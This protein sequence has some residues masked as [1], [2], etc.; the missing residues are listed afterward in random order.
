MPPL[1]VISV[2]RCVVPTCGAQRGSITVHRLPKDPVR[3]NIWKQAIKNPE[4]DNI[5]PS[6]LTTR[7]V[8]CKRHFDSD[9]YVPS[10]MRPTLREWAIPT[11]HLPEESTI[12]SNTGETD[13]DAEYEFSTLTNN[14]DEDATYN[15]YGNQSSSG[16]CNEIYE[17]EEGNLYD[18][19]DVDRGVT[20]SVPQKV[21]H[22]TFKNFGE[23][24]SDKLLMT[25]LEKRSRDELMLELIRVRKKVKV[26]QQAN[27]RLNTQVHNLK[28]LNKNLKDRL[29][30]D[31]KTKL[32]ALKESNYIN[33]FKLVNNISDAQP[34]E[35]T[36]NV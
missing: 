9:S 5:D 16:E 23:M 28:C 14:S 1:K 10:T 26:L 31:S 17:S 12:S 34:V 2:G 29:V 32:R 19:E 20:T 15:D 3:L 6:T 35:E 30:K 33:N 27:R 18:A 4:I 7:Y 13:D 8:I 21:Y 22:R 25:S 11:L 36:S 24:K